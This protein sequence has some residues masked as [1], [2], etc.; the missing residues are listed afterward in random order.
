[1]TARPA[2]S[3]VLDYTRQ[4]APV[5]LNRE[6][7]QAV[8]ADVGVDVLLATSPANVA[9]L[10]GY[11]CLSH[12]T[13]PGTLVLAALAPAADPG[14]VVVAPAME[15][16]A[17]AEEPAADGE[18]RPYGKPAAAVGRAVGVPAEDLVADDR[19]IYDHGFAGETAA[20]AVDALVAALVE[21][22]HTRATIALDE[23]GLTY[24]ARQALVDRLPDATIVD[25]AA[26]FKRIRMV[27]TPVEVERLRAATVVAGDSI[28]AALDGIAPGVTEREVWQ[29]YNAEVASRGAGTTFAV[30]NFGRRTGHT[31]TIPSDYR[32]RPGDVVKFDGG[33]SYQMYQSDIGRTKVVGD[34]TDELARVYEALHVGQQTGIAA[35]RPGVRPSEVFE[36]TMAAV[37]DAG[38]PD[39]QRHHVGH[40]IGLEVY[41]MPVI[42][43]AASA[44][45]F[46]GTGAN[47]DPIEA[48]MVFC[49]ET[50]Y[51][52]LGSYG[53]IVEDTVVVTPTGARYLTDLPRD[54]RC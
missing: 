34:P 17:W 50:P 39:Y 31:H 6:R 10:S 49:I 52:V 26:V 32:L 33:C 7:A 36:S 54:L 46:G 14:P 47:D 5:L 25:G 12:W 2:G 43:P 4:V 16:D 38:L 28:A 9:Y 8:L 37:K 44:S 15:L 30:I 13:N 3:L 51:Y 22:G 35:L 24:S 48:G 19:F 20:G 41:D 27:K 21:R 29:A 40:G 18:F 45:E 1:M 11:Y 23:S 53:M 42:Q